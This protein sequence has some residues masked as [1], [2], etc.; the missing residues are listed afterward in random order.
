MG[1]RPRRAWLDFAGRAGS[2][3]LAK[4]MQEREFPSQLASRSQQTVLRFAFH[5]LA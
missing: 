2:A 3:N 4:R 1:A 5:R